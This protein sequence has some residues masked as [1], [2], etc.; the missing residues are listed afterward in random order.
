M[1]LK[2]EPL[3]L[4]N[5]LQTLYT[6]NAGIESSVHGLVFSN[7]SES[8]ATFNLTYYRASTNTTYTLADN[9]TVPPRKNYAWPRPINMGPADY[10]RSSSTTTNVITVT[11][12]VYENDK[13]IAKGFTGQG[14]W[15][16]ANLYFVNDVV[17]YDGQSYIAI[18]ENTN[19][20]P[21]E[22]PEWMLLAARGFVGYTG[23]QGEQGIP[24]PNTI[25]TAEDVEIT[26]LKDGSVLVYKT[27]I[28]KWKATDILDSQTVDGGQF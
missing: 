2:I 7:N 20:I 18:D 1:S 26:D 28:S 11:A 14:L 5:S 21:S 22:N 3:V 19:K 15:D 6:V 27:Q 16:A 25:N 10:L 12:S 24:G 23:S 13:L 17:L 8:V 9:F 4:T